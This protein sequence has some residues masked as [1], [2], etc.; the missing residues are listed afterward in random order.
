ML[1][2]DEYVESGF[3]ESPSPSEPHGSVK[4]LLGALEDEYPPPTEA[5]FDGFGP[6]SIQ[7]RP[8][9]LPALP[10]DAALSEDSSNSDQSDRDQ[11][12]AREDAAIDGTH[13]PTSTMVG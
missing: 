3:T 7:Y 10:P 12:I 5:D 11:R 1:E 6:R 2:T 9:L 8:A 4:K 13:S